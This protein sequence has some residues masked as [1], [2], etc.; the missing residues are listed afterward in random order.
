MDV[1]DE[2]VSVQFGTHFN[3]EGPYARTYTD[4]HTHTRLFEFN[5]DVMC[6]LDFLLRKANGTAPFSWRIPLFLRSFA[7]GFGRT[8]PLN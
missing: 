8:E 1:A 3:F 4:T 2:I 6:S 7:Y 5:I